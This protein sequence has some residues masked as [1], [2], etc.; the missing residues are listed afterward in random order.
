[1]PESPQIGVLRGEEYLLALLLRVIEEACSNGAGKLNSWQRPAYAAALRELA[2]NGLVMIGSDSDREVI[3][4]VT[5]Q[6]EAF[7]KRLE[8]EEGRQTSGRQA[9]D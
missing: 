6:G 4:K 7:L 3:A 1:M 9:G 8:E 2:S 5:R